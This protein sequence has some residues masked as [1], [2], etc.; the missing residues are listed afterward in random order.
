MTYKATKVESKG[1]AMDKS[2]EVIILGSLRRPNPLSDLTRVEDYIEVVYELIEKKGYARP[3]DI[4]EQLGVKSAS[5]T[6]MLQKLHAMGLIV[7]ERYRGLTLTSSGERL[8]RSVQQKHLTILKFLRILGIEEK[9]AKL[10]A[11][12]IEHHLHNTTIDRISRFVQYVAQHP[13]WYQAF[14]ETL[15]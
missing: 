3:V 14:K 9:T 10:D 2:T 8:A 6:S 4:A 7:Y 1:K 5:V 11:E 13:T 12:G 15:K